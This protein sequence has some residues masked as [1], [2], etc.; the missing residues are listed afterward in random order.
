[1]AEFRQKGDSVEFRYLEDR[2]P[3]AIEHGIYGYPGLA[4][5]TDRHRH[6]AIKSMRRRVPPRSR[7]GL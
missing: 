2:L 4:M 7:G 6:T 3:A 1:M 5:D